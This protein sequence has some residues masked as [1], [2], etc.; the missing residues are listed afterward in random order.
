MQHPRGTKAL[1]RFATGQEVTITV[2]HNKHGR[3]RFLG[4][5]LL[6]EGGVQ[7]FYGDMKR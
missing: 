4:A 7:A 1:K 6:P 3:L 5:H 2:T